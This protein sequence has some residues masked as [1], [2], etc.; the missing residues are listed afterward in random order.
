[1]R[2]LSIALSTVLA[3]LVAACS[4]QDIAEGLTPQAE[5]QF[6]ENY[7]RRLLARDF[8]YVKQHLDAGVAPQVTDKVL[9]EM[10][11]Q[12]SA[13]ELLSIDLIGSRVLSSSSQLQSN[14]SFELQFSENWMLANI[15]LKT[16][17][18]TISVMG[19][20][21]QRLNASLRSANAFTLEGKSPLH[22][23]VLMLAMVVSVFTLVTLYFCVRTPRLKLK[24][25]WLVFVLIGIG[26]MNL[27]WTTG[28]YGFQLW[29]IMLLSASA[30]TP[31]PLGPWIISVSLP[32]GAIL[33]WFKRQR[34]MA[35]TRAAGGAGFEA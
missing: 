4:Y 16:V 17:N 35:A 19:L 3:L 31:G 14:F 15:A 5:S 34:L 1:M 32:L 21:G 29:S 8:D 33:F 26:S 30:V 9:L 22:Y 24:W 27:N 2:S 28:Q 7:L 20:S 12:F 25:L 11:E 10:V 6:A 18:D 13:G 23:L